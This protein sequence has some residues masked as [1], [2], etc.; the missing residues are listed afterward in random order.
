VCQSC[1]DTSIEEANSSVVVGLCECTGVVAPMLGGGHGWLQGEHGLMTDNLVSARL[2]LANAIT[3]TVSADE[4]ADLFWALR[5]AGHNFG[6]VTSFEYRMYDRVPERETWTYE[7]FVFEQDKLQQVYELLNG[8]MDE[9]DP[10]FAHWST[11]AQQ[12]DVYDKVT[13][14]GIAQ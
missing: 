13:I 1:R 4:H 6:T 11:W 9:G 14:H 8:F 2:T 3:I 5:G 12:P 10:S 7:T